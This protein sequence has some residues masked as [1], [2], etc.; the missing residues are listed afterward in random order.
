MIESPLWYDGIRAIHD[1][2]F[3]DD[4]Q[5]RVNELNRRLTGPQDFM[6]PHRAYPPPWFNGDIERLEPGRW[7]L[8]G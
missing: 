1:R 3:G 2:H 7:V 5:E 6:L 4:W 8:V